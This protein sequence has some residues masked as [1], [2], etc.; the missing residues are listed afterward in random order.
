[1][2]RWPDRARARPRPPRRRRRPLRRW[3]TGTIALIG[4]ISAAMLGVPA[5]IAGAAPAVPLTLKQLLARA[6][7]LSNEIDNLSQQYDGLKIQLREAR[8][9]IQIARE[10]EL[11]DEKLLVASRAAVGQ[12]AAVGYMADGLNPTLQLLQGNKPQTFL[13]RASILVQ[14]DQENGAK[15]NAVTAAEAAARR[16][17]LNAQQQSRRAARLATEMT[18]KVAAIQAREN[19]LNSAAFAQAMAVYRQTGHYP[20]IE[21]RGDSLGVQ[22]LR[23]ALTRLGDPY[24]WGGAGP[25]DFDCSGLVMWAYAQVGISLEH[26]TGDQWNEGVHIPR[27]ELE[28]GDLVFFFPD[29]SHVGMYVGHGLMIDAPT[30]GQPVQIQRIY[31]SD[32]VGAV[33]IV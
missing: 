32:F 10:T 31:W 18:A 21:V 8:G 6:N 3:P 9:E 30:F 2:Q 7:R 24:E 16:A 17:Q 28:P 25:H 14:L 29:I 4:A 13:N 11:R 26:Y 20:N 1:V 27:S 12:I 33:R 23:F 5:G 15:L 19:V 22:A